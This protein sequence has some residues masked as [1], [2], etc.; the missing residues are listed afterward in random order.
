MSRYYGI[1]NEVKS[2]CNKLQ[3][4][5]GIS[6]SQDTIKTLND[7]VEGLKRNNLWASCGLGFN[8]ADGDSFIKKANV[9]D[10]IG[11]AEILWF[12]RGMKSIGLWSNMI[13]WPLRSYQN[14]GT[15]STVYS[16]GGAGSF[17]G[18]CINSP[19]WDVNGIIFGGDTANQRIDT[20]FASTASS[21]LLLISVQK[22][23]QTGTNPCTVT[24]DPSTGNRTAG[25]NLGTYVYVFNPGFTVSTDTVQ[26]PDLGTWNFS[27]LIYNRSDGFYG[28]YN[29]SPRRAT[30]SVSTDL[31]SG[32]LL[33][34]NGRRGLSNSNMMT[35]TIAFGMYLLTTRGLLDYLTIRNLYKSTL[36]NGLGL[37]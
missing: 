9:T 6:L 16:L 33:G 28:M 35:G 26:A 1:Q 11:R 24:V 19:T 3:K 15:V 8:D 31:T 27:N 30:T 7:R 18:T 17:D 22:R 2:Y 34:I 21:N 5:Q 14:I 20:S 36:G 10:P 25:I 12:V 29:T 4:E 23:D 32:G 37:P 13:C